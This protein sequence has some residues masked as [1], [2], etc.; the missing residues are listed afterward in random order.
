M[1]RFHLS[2]GLSSDAGKEAAK[3]SQ[4][5]MPDSSWLHSVALLHIIAAADTVLELTTDG[6]HHYDM[7]HMKF[8]AHYILPRWRM[9][10][11]QRH[12]PALTRKGIAKHLRRSAFIIELQNVNCA[13]A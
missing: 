1:L 4:V 7:L 12:L 11:A 9:A 6:N 2:P 5:L 10:D 13:K 8:D 3:I